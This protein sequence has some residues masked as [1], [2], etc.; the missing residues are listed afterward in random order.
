MGNGGAERVIMR[1][2]NYLRKN[3]HDVSIV[4]ATD[5]GVL[6]NSINID[7]HYLGSKY[8][9]LSVFRF[10]EYLK[11]KKPDIVLS[12]L[13]SAII[14]AGITRLLTIK[15]NYALIM[16]I[17][18][19]VRID[20]SNFFRIILESFAISLCDGVIVN[21]K[22]TKESIKKILP[23]KLQIKP[24]MVISNPVLDD[25]FELKLKHFKR[26]RRAKKQVIFIGRFTPQKQ[27]MHAIK[28]FKIIKDRI[29]NVSML[30]IGDGCEKEEI[31]RFINAQ[32]LSDV[33]SIQQYC[34]DIPGLLMNADCLINTSKYEG[35]GNIFI[36]GLAYCD[37]LVCYQSPGGA[38]ELLKDTSAS[39]VDQGDIE[40]LANAVIK[41]LLENNIGSKD[42]RFLTKFSE[43]HICAIYENFLM[44]IR[45]SK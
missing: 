15:N 14:V 27:V 38:S 16:R 31:I 32:D 44:N 40:G 1:L 3:D 25:N 21:S 5:K 4:S 22:A 39:L 6:S 9:L 34:D 17:A 37:N 28:A 24:T 23:L 18:N 33:I 43:S 35:F 7:V 11:I 41:R 42:L 30:I 29:D 2:Y 36:E 20:Q 19:I 8:A 12:T 26:K 10:K 45:E 13:S